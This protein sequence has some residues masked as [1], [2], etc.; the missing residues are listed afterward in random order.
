MGN[1]QSKKDTKVEKDGNEK[2]ERK[3]TN[4]EKRPS[5]FEKV[6][7]DVFSPPP[8]QEET[9]RPPKHM[10]WGCET[11]EEHYA[12]I[13]ETCA[14]APS[15]QGEEG[16]RE[17]GF[18]FRMVHHPDTCVCED[19]PFDDDD[20]EGDSYLMNDTMALQQEEE[21]LVPIGVPLEAHKGLE[22]S[23]TDIVEDSIERLAHE[24]DMVDGDASSSDNKTSSMPPKRGSNMSL[25]SLATH[26]SAST[27]ASS[28]IP[29]GAISY[30]A[31]VDA[32]NDIDKVCT[33]R[34]HHIPSGGTMVTPENHQDFIAHGKMYDEIARLCMQM[35]QETMMKEGDLQW[36]SV[37]DVRNI[38]A[39]VSKQP[40][41]SNK[42]LLIVTGKGQVRAGIFSRRHLLTSG[43]ESSTALPLIRE[44]TQRNMKIVML[45]PNAKGHQ[46]GMEVV[47]A[48]LEKL[49]FDEQDQ[50]EEIY[51]VAHSMAGAQL[52]RF[53]HKHESS[54][55]RSDGA[56]ESKSAGNETS[57][58]ADT[59]TTSSDESF[60]RKIKAVAFTDANH[61]VNWCRDTPS[62]K[63]LLVGPSCLYV[64]SHKIHDEPKALGQP[65]HYC[66]FW[67]HRFGEIRTIWAG[68]HEH[69]LT[70]YTARYHIWD[71]FDE[72]LHPERR[73]EGS[74]AGSE[75]D[76][77]TYYGAE[78][79]IE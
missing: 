7:S 71:H 4:N 44:A 77:Q 69:A 24:Q 32:A 43:V 65:H 39:L 40:Q 10:L 11:P 61:N 35:A 51:V 46:M 3:S 59:S 6:L 48:S 70:N 53:L 42:V 52:V 50:D 75:E 19:M 29:P 37:C 34:L 72:F 45:D 26:Y 21:Y 36:V 79:L 33:W 55:T 41:K 8:P 22:R 56:R 9:I 5:F 23:M 31:G 76:F 12:K 49:F 73:L 58:Q 66:D 78:G 54:S 38:Q 63:N 13:Q 18:E 27:T 1:E 28:S 57:N 60:L 25:F 64:K 47:E 14:K 16:L 2:E 67:Q 30:P 20:D 68:T 17:L 74:D 15:L 62:V